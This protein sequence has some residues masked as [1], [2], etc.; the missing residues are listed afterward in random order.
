MNITEFANTHD[1]QPQ[2]I[3]RYIDRHPQFFSGHTQK[4]G[5]SIILDDV[6][7]GLL[8]EQ[9][10]VPKPVQIINGIPIED[11]LRALSQK[12][13][14]IQQLQ[15]EII[16][17]QKI[18]NHTLTELCALKSSK[19][20]LESKMDT[21][22]IQLALKDDDIQRANNTI[23][24]LTEKLNAIKKANIIQRILQAY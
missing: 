6:A 16:D 4:V 22:S 1:Q 5:K 20:L 11:H 19:V 2:T 21:Y 7:I 10:P 17:L 18:V 3:K 9:Y 15:A 13:D 12:D 23:N 8:D 24:E 14:D